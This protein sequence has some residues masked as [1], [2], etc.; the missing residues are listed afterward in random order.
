MSSATAAARCCGAREGLV[1][2]CAAV[3][4]EILGVSCHILKIVKTATGVEKACLVLLG[5]QLAT[6]PETTEREGKEFA[7]QSMG[8]C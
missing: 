8:G 4:L 7:Q 3:L 2:A 5:P 6:K 1:P